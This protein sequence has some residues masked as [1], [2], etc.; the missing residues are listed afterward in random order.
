MLSLFYL[1][2]RYET[3]PRSFYDRNWSTNL[4]IGFD[5]SE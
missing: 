4:F 2:T 5:E 3:T 1:R